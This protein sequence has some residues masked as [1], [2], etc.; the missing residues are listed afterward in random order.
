VHPV[1]HVSAYLAVV[2]AERLQLLCDPRS[3]DIARRA[4]RV[5][6]SCRT[7]GE[8]RPERAAQLRR[9]RARLSAR[10]GQS[11]DQGIRNIPAGGLTELELP[12][13]PGRRTLDSLE[14][15]GPAHGVLADLGN[16]R[17]A[18]VSESPD[19]PAGLNRGHGQERRFPDPRG[20]RRAQLLRWL[21]CR[22]PERRVHLSATG[23]VGRRDLEVP[24]GVVTASTPSQRDA[25]THETQVLGV[26][27][28]RF[29]PLNPRLRQGRNPRDVGE[30]REGGVRPRLKG[31]LGLE[32][33]GHAECLLHR[34][35]RCA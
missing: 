17:P 22:T 31:E 5:D 35:E 20:G 21:S 24:A 29:E 19:Q 26:E 7:G 13:R 16:E 28:D 10:L 23:V 12:F 4:V 25:R 9:P 8:P 18:I 30:I 6:L 1:A 34:G 2:D 32:L 14:K 27:V 3:H 15:A 11:R 33:F